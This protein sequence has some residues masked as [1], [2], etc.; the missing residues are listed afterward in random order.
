MQ[1]DMN[2]IHVWVQ[3][4]EDSVLSTHYLRLRF[5]WFY[6]FIFD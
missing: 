4:E 6:S 5:L 1:Q 3:V 2:L